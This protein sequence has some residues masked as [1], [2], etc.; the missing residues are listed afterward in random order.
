MD[1]QNKLKDLKGQAMMEYLMTYGFAI[2]VIV[3]ILAALAFYL[4][5]FI[6][7][8]ATCLFDKTEFDCQERPPG[9]VGGADD[10]VNL[11]IKIQNN[12]NRAVVLTRVLCT[13]APKGEINKNMGGVVVLNPNQTISAGA[14]TPE[15]SPWVAFECTG[16]DGATELSLA[17]NSEFRGH[18][19]VWYRYK[20]DLPGIPERKAIAVVTGKVLEG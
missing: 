18:F 11:V 17:P 10:S 14:S 15:V 20:D 7:T 19:A 8:P 4:P 6:N 2:F 16:K 13:T 1:K 9:L 12:D 3:V 5:Q